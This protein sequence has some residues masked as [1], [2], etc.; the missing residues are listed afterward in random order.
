[1]MSDTTNKGAKV[2]LKVWIDFVCPYCLLGESIVDQATEGL[3]VDIEWMPLELRP[4]PTPTLRPEDDYLPRA[5]ESGVY[6]TAARMGIP[7]KLPTVSPQPY[8]RDAFLG[9][10]YAA[11]QGK[12]TEY[13]DAVL[14]AFFQQDRDIGDLDVLRDIANNL[15]LDLKEFEAALNSKARQER[16]EA[17]LEYAQKVGIRAVPSIAVGTKLYSGMPESSTLRAEILAQSR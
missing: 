11:E 1:M 4:Y 2:A 5:W 16:H 13:A 7:I 14:K 15:S 17:A 8:T 9:L 10:Q 3:D 12:G 6:P